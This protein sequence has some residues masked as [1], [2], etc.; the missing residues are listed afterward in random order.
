MAT[1]ELLSSGSL[2]GKFLLI[3][4]CLQPSSQ[5]AWSTAGLT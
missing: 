1:E 2:Q 5:V 3:L 4:E